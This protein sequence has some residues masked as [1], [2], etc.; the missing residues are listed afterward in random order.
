MF[1]ISC[2]GSSESSRHSGVDFGSRIHYRDNFIQSKFVTLWGSRAVVSSSNLMPLP[3]TRASCLRLPFPLKNMIKMQTKN[4]SPSAHHPIQDLCVSYMGKNKNATRVQ[5][6]HKEKVA[7]ALR[8]LLRGCPEMTSLFGGE[9]GV[10]QKMTKG[11][12]GKGGV[13]LIK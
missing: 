11:N 4:L 8:N 10:S 7:I 9:G 2:W 13:R 12:Q 3:F 6:T 5:S 1:H